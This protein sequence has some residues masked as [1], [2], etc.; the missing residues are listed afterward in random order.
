[1]TKSEEELFNEINTIVESE[2]A[3][4]INSLKPRI[5]E[6]IQ[7]YT[8]TVAVEAAR[9]ARIDELKNS[10]RELNKG[11]FANKLKY[12][13]ERLDTLNNTQSEKGTE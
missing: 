1:M 12:Y 10:F 11:D 4:Y 9:E 13:D 3:H 2:F 6:A 8:A 5:I 7:G